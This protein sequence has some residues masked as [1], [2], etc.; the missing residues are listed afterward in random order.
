MKIKKFH[1]QGKITFKRILGWLA[2]FITVLLFAVFMDWLVLNW[3]SHCCED[4]GVCIPD[5]YPSCRNPS[6]DQIYGEGYYDTHR[7]AAE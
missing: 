2:T 1:I 7:K 6:Y 4:G 5:F 3:L